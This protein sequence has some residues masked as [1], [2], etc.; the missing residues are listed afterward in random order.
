MS[1]NGSVEDRL[2]I[3]ELIEAYGDAVCQHD[4]EAWA[5][6]WCDDGIW[7]MPSI[8]SI[9]TL[10]GKDQIM[11]VWIAAMDAL[12]GMVM[13]VT[14]G[15]ITVDG[16]RA[17][18]RSYISEA[19]PRGSEVARDRGMFEDEIV[20]RDGRWLFQKRTFNYTSRA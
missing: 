17:T 6:L 10:V 11:P 12:R 7:D 4:A 2:A 14:V 13:L 19:Y 1:A 18:A 8:P 5:D 3:R 16:D 20:R 15:K 9:G